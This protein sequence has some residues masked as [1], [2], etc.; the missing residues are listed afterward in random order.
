MFIAHIRTRAVLMAFGVAITATCVA[1]SWSLPEEA[2]YTSEDGRW[3]LTV[4]PLELSSQLAYFEDKVAGKDKAG[5]R[6][7]GHE[8]ARGLLQKRT[9]KDWTTVWNKALLN[10]VAPVDVLIASTGQAVTLDNWHTMGRGDETIVIYDVKGLPV[11]SLGL[12]DLLPAVVVDNLPRSV[13]SIQWRT[14]SRVSD[15]GDVLLLAI[16]SP[17]VMKI[18][19]GLIDPAENAF[20][21]GL[22]MN[23]CTVVP[24]SKELWHEVVATAEQS[25]SDADEEQE[26]GVRNTLRH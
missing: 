12:Y 15:D 7:D 6:P 10:D 2:T 23:D 26:L 19:H 25:Q 13:S 9:G 8:K 20:E 5:A 21:L 14:A 22:R 1:D 11:C 17:H 4:T 18:N 24:P 16:A 3:R